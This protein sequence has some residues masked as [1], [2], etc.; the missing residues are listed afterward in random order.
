MKKYF[1]CVISSEQLQQTPAETKN[2]FGKQSNFTLINPTTKTLF[3]KS[4]LP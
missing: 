4:V 2:Q 3:K 1:Q